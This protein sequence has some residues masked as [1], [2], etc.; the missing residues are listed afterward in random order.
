MAKN[1][2][3]NHADLEQ[4]MK[5]DRTDHGGVVLTGD[6]T[7]TW[8]GLPFARLGDKVMCFKC[9]GIFKIDEGD[10]NMLADGIP[11]AFDGYKVACGAKLIAE[12]AGPAMK[13]A[14]VAFQ[15]GTAHDEQFRLTGSDNSPL[16]G[17]PYTAVLPTAEQIH[18][19]TDE[20]GMT[21]RFYSDGSISVKVY[22]GDEALAKQHEQGGA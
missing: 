11:R 4:I 15:K 13:A 16:V 3:P 10:P 18:G 9:K 6:E 1:R 8:H 2:P 7:K 17:I 20:Q 5:G 19:T 14:A 12:Q 21:E 22:W